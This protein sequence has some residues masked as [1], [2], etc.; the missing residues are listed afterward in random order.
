MRLILVRHGE[1][2]DNR[3][4]RMMSSNGGP[5][6]NAAGRAQAG[7]IASALKDALPFRLYSSSARRARETA[8]LVS[9]AL[10]VPFTVVDDLAETDV[11]AIEGL[12]E[13]ELRLA[14]PGYFA[15]WER[16]NATSRPPGGET[17]QELQDRAWRA[18]RRLYDAHPD[19]TVVAVSHCFT[20]S[21]VVARVLEMPL[22][23]FRRVRL[24]LGAMARIELTPAGAEIVS[25]N[26]TWHLRPRI[27]STLTGAGE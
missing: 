25:A 3:D 6:L 21:T 20:I 17:V 27:H 9:E 16:D 19:G 22:R 13:H 1:T 10:G 11:G 26:E 24:D 7:H 23:H 4:G 18:V 2:D 12:T 5:P 15:E 8:G 14:Y